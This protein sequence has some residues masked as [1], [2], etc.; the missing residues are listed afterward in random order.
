[1]QAILEVLDE[2]GSR[3]AFAVTP[4][5]A[6]TYIGSY[7]GHI[8]TVIQAGRDMGYAHIVVIQKRSGMIANGKE[9][10]AVTFGETPGGP[11]YGFTIDSARA[12]AIDALRPPQAAKETE[13]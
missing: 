9:W 7:T 1:M 11:F 12:Q 2:G 3:K 5:G 6:R 8:P 10:A 13:K 4:N